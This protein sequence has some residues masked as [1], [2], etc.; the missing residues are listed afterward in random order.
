[1]SEAMQLVLCGIAILFVVLLAIRIVVGTLKFM[2]EWAPVV[3]FLGAAAA[4]CYMFNADFRKDVGDVRAKYIESVEAQGRYSQ[5][6][7]ERDDNKV[8]S[9][10][11]PRRKSIKN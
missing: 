3:V 7:N 5:G 8:L 6:G 4:L 2:Y 1:M 11:T 9:P 10:I